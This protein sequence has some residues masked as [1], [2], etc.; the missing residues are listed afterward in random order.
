MPAADAINIVRSPILATEED[1]LTAVLRWIK[2]HSPRAGG[3]ASSSAADS[4]CVGQKRAR[5]AASSDGNDDAADSASLHEHE[6]VAFEVLSSVSAAGIPMQRLVDEV[7]ELDFVSKS[8]LLQLMSAVATAAAT[9]ADVSMGNCNSWQPPFAQRLR[10]R[11]AGATCAFGTYRDV[12][13]YASD[14]G[15]E[16]DLPILDHSAPKPGSQLGVTYSP[17]KPGNIGVTTLAIVGD[18]HGESRWRPYG[19]PESFATGAFKRNTV[20]VLL[21]VRCPEACAFS[22]TLFFPRSDSASSLLYDAVRMVFS[23]D[24]VGRLHTPELDPVVRRATANEDLSRTKRVHG[25]VV[26]FDMLSL[27]KPCSPSERASSLLYKDAISPA[28][29]ITLRLER[30]R[31]DGVDAVGRTTVTIL[32]NGIP[33]SSTQFPRYAV[34][35]WLYAEFKHTAFE[36]GASITTMGKRSWMTL[37]YQA[38]EFLLFAASSDPLAIIKP[39]LLPRFWIVKISA[40]LLQALHGCNYRAV[41]MDPCDAA[42]C[43]G[44]GGLGGILKEFEHHLRQS[45]VAPAMDGQY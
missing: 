39:S 10:I 33:M 15:Y 34:A 24:T 18:L 14:D 32:V 2:H 40:E 8:A 44:L 12:E 23:C 16:E 13:D 20:E 9:E 43:E 42:T 36:Q 22:P 6:D 1:I 4:G 19:G 31:G 17:S 41:A 25:E 5:A 27:P 29:V 37:L 21:S 26:Q 38:L 45:A 35:S 7:G 30:E 3:P 11:L 28:D